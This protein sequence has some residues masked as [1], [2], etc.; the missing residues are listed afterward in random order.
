MG[1][2]RTDRRARIKRRIRKKIHG[3]AACP[4]LLVYRGV[5]NI[6][7]Q[8][9]DD[10]ANRVLC[11]VHSTALKQ[12]EASGESGKIAISKAVGLQIAAKAKE[13]SI[14]KVVFDRS[15]YRYH[16]R[17]KALADGARE[18]GLEF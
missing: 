11:S 8:L 17:V 16:G 10:D 6:E 7:A 2:L 9:A 5:R 18:G 12:T 14:T 13:Q 3:T 1:T 4:R 15:G